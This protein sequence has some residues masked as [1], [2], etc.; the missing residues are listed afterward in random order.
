MVEIGLAETITVLGSSVAC[1]SLKPKC[2]FEYSFV[3]EH[4]GTIPYSNHCKFVTVIYTWKSSSTVVENSVHIRPKLFFQVYPE[5]SK[6]Y[7][8]E[9]ERSE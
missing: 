4:L 5:V 6:F 8:C 3:F 2:L 7:I 1:W 9:S